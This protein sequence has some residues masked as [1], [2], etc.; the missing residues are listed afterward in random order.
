MLPKTIVVELLI[1]YIFGTIIGTF[2]IVFS[3]LV[4]DEI[5]IIN[6]CGLN[7]NVKRII[8]QRA[9]QDMKD[10]ENLLKDD[11]TIIPSKTYENDD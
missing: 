2:I 11:K 3:L 1:L 10:M 9:S 6:K 7:H 8:E 5:I 4:Y